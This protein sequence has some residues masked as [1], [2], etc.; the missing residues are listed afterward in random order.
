M[1]EL[2][3]P[4]LELSPS[5]G[6]F[7]AGLECS[8]VPSPFFSAVPCH[9][10]LL[11][12]NGTAVAAVCQGKHRLVTSPK[13]DKSRQ[14]RG[15]CETSPWE[16]RKEQRSWRDNLGRKHVSSS[17]HP[18]FTARQNA[19]PGSQMLYSRDTEQ[20]PQRKGQNE[21][22]EFQR[23]VPHPDPPWCPSLPGPWIRAEV[24][25]GMAVT[26]NQVLVLDHSPLLQHILPPDSPPGS[27]LELTVAAA[28]LGPQMGT[29]S[30]A[31]NCLN[32]F[33]LQP[34]ARE[35]ENRHRTL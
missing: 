10:C 35:M 9:S 30:K 29:F 21:A 4:V 32:R 1:L 12:A 27:L 23:A 28:L 33:C 18:A 2:F 16:G 19:L 24:P 14:Q 20:G 34:L 7:P 11:P 25:A 5:A 22:E 15:H 13:S 17:S 26:P 31:G 3:P 6:I 8:L